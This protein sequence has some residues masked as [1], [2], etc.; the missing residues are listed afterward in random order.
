L[1]AEV[2]AIRFID[3]ETLVEDFFPG[4]EP[5]PRIAWNQFN[6]DRR[7]DKAM[8]KFKV[9]TRLHRYGVSRLLGQSGRLQQTGRSKGI[10]EQVSLD[11]P[12]KEMRRRA[13]AERMLARAERRLRQA[14][15]LVDKWKLRLAERDR[16]GIDAKQA[17]LWPEE[18]PDHEPATDA[19][20]L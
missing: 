9:H 5:C 16:A 8:K 18:E 1:L 13:H 2:W 12:D 11:S 15:N 4:S 19:L 17:N 3:A 20:A 6:R 14:A 7:R 10:R